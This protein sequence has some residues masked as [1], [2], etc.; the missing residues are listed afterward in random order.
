MIKKK[1]EEDYPRQTMTNQN[2]NLE[3]IST[4]VPENLQKFPNRRNI[5]NVWEIYECSPL[6]QIQQIYHILHNWICPFISNIRVVHFQKYLYV[7]LKFYSK[8]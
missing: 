7:F 5:L 4:K 2:P 3:I 6:E 1:Q 8:F